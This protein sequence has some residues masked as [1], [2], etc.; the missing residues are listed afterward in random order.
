M[1]ASS[2]TGSP[3]SA[4]LVGVEKHDRS[5]SPNAF[6]FFVVILPRSGLSEGRIKNRGV[7]QLI[8]LPLPL[9]LFFIAIFGPKIACQ[10][11]N[12]PNPLPSNNIRVAR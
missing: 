10:V 2:E 11:Q 5:P 6:A 9:Q 8:L 4:L 12:P 7:K 3:T 1:W